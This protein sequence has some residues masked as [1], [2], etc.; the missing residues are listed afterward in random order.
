MSDSV[1]RDKGGW[2]S[3]VIR[4]VEHDGRPAVLKDYRTRSFLARNL[5]ALFLVRREYQ[6]LKR[7]E[8]VGG[9]PRA[10]GVVEGRALLLEYIEG[11]TSGKF[12]PGDLPLSVYESLR[13]TVREIH[14]RGVVHL[15]L[16]QKKNI[17]ITDAGK[18]CVIDFGG[19][20]A[21]P[22][23]SPLRLL[24]P[25]FRGVD[26][27]AVLKFKQRNFPSDLTE[28]EQKRLKRHRFWRRFWIFTPRGKYVR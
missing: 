11:R 20:M 14:R 24:M 8:G 12:K 7:L 19:G 2:L 6:I 4:R 15:D 13:E 17:L 28:R 10:F 22:F 18:P 21:P 26:E 25:L 9:V 16:R 5:F 1:L 23:F 27:L 3:P